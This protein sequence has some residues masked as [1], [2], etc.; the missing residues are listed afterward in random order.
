MLIVSLDRL[1]AA[2]STAAGTRE[3]PAFL[4]HSL[5]SQLPYFGKRR[6][7]RF[8]LSAGVRMASFNNVQAIE[9]ST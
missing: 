9:P 3:R 5:V 2:L 6:A 8:D 7:M 4:S 1:V